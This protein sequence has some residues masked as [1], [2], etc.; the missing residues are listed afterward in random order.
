MF[1]PWNISQR[2][3]EIPTVHKTQRLLHVTSKNCHKYLDKLKYYVT[4]PETGRDVWDISLCNVP[5]STKTTRRMQG[6]KFTPSANFS[7]NKTFPAF[8]WGK[9]PSFTTPEL[10]HVLWHCGESIR[11]T[12][13]LLSSA[14][15][16]ETRNRWEGL[17]TTD[18]RP[19]ERGSPYPILLFYLS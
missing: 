9:S 5:V 14:L 8:P 11:W 4:T 17:C 10:L 13:P 6:C 3:R 2:K 7:S 12:F 16:F 18:V 1:S 15:L 19:I